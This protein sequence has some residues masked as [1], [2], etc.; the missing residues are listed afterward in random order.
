MGTNRSYYIGL[1]PIQFITLRFHS[2]ISALALILLSAPLAMGEVA[3]LDT[4]T[5]VGTP[6]KLTVQTRGRLFSQGGQRVALYR[7][8]H[9]IARIL[10]GGD[11]YGYFTCRFN[12]AGF[13]TIEAYSGR[14]RGSGT[15]LVMTREEKAVIVELEGFIADAFRAN[16][17]APGSREA[18]ETLS[19]HHRLLYLTRS[20]WAPVSRGWLKS[21]RMPES[22][23]LRWRGSA[24]LQNL[25]EKGVCV[26]AAI[27]TSRFLSEV[28]DLVDHKVSF[29]P[30]DSG[31]TVKNWDE[32]VE[33]LIPPVTD[34]PHSK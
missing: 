4:V 25:I 31:H 17:L 27:G 16:R 15:V 12:T 19:E 20:L 3:I 32:L 18:M 8:D 29:E 14:D 22:V 1:K 5:T 13:K 21:M 23:L 9:P 34:R 30:T 6:V 26:H 24:T 33:R 2:F 7:D 11:G 10:T 28:A